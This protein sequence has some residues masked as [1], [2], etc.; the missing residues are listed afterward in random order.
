ML[1]RFLLY[2]C[3]G[4]LIEVVFTGLCAVFL[5]R[6]KGATGKTY[7]WMHPIYGGTALLLEQVHGE[8][9]GA[10]LPLR[11]LVYLAII[12]AAEYSTGALLRALLGRCP[13]DYGPRRTAIHGL[14]RLD[15]APAWFAVGIFAEYAQPVIASFAAALLPGGPAAGL[16]GFL[17][18]P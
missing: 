5:D 16:L 4:L 1:G 15:Y 11:G 3:V 13:W 12:Y 8:L 17:A 14:I 2:G 7:L 6:D 10:P 9:G 18:L